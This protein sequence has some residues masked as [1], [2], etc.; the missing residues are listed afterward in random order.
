MS[1]EQ[2]RLLILGCSQRKLPHS[3]PLPAINRYDGPS[4]RVLRRFL[5]MR[6]VQR[7]DAYILSTEFGLIPTHALIPNYDRRMTP[8]R[9]HQLQPT[10]VAKIDEVLACERHHELFICMGRTYL[11]ALDGYDK[12]IP[13]SI[14]V[15]VATGTSG[16]Q[17]SQLY[18]WLNGTPPP[19]VAGSPRA[20]NGLA[21]I[22]GVE[23]PA[24]TTAEVLAIA[25]HGL[26]RKEDGLDAY[27]SWYVSVEGQR[28]APKWLVSQLSG[29]PVGAFSTDDARR[30]LAQLGVDVERV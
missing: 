4:Y 11:R 25:R 16:R 22:R 10:V 8:E 5:R 23:L 1:I 13:S 15:Q 17:L 20:K 28:V 3:C 21:R 29:L 24:T 2:R 30:L 7:V 12:L 18:D 19:T 6:S 9:A 14:A 27:Q 26:E